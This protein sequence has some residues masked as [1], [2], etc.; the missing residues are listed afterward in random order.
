[1]NTY[2]DDIDVWHWKNVDFAHRCEKYIQQK[3]YGPIIS[4]VIESAHESDILPQ[5]PHHSS[6]DL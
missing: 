6:M 3:N 1:M 5:K 4:T 2:R